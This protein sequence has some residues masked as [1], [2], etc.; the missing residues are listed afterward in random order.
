MTENID[1]S[2]PVRLTAFLEY[3]RVERAASENTVSAYRRDLNQ[4]LAEGQGLTRAGIER[5]LTWLRGEK[6]APASIRR[7][8]AALSSFCRFLEG[9]GALAENPVAQVEALTRPEGKLPRVL[10]AHDVARLLN[11]PDRQL[12]KGRRDAAL[13]ELMYAS[14]LRVSEVVGLRVGD[15]DA[16]RGLLRV[17][18]KGGKE[19]LTPVARPALEALAGYQRGVKRAASGPGAFIFPGP[20][21]GGHIGRGLVWRA[22][23]EHARRAGL[24]EMPS[25]HWLRHSFATHLLNGGADIR[26]IQEMLGHARIATTQVYTHVATDRLRRAYRAAHPRA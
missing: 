25:P 11:E 1:P 24:P 13:M 6:L 26:A 18:G 4:W 8:R 15:V 17:R 3:L 14:G 16:K 20:T 22:V 12:V 5:Y 10:T 23:K 9:E 19:R 7:K 21:G 2:L